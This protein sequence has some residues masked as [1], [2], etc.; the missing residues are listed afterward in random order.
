MSQPGSIAAWSAPPSLRGEHV[1]LEPMLP[2]H[3]EALRKAVQDGELWKA[4]YGSTPAPET[5]DA[6][7]A[8]AMGMQ[9]AGTALPFV[10]RDAAGEIVG[11]TRYYDIA[12]NVP[13]LHI[14]YTW[15]AARVQRTGLNTQAKLLLLAHAFET[16]G[17]LAVGFKTS[18]YNEA[19]R[20]AIL[21]L[22]AKQDGVLRN[23][24]RH[25]DGS[26]RDSVV[27][28]ILDSEW[29]AAKSNLLAKLERHRHG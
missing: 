23:H 20:A 21:R 4:W 17:C 15:Y 9:A 7:V 18:W 28:S 22:G 10:V 6:Y 14:G 26:V 8:A 29:P 3:T 27:F 1:S 16:L 11:T 13:R 25:N 12:R 5:M 2:E 24:M 19:S